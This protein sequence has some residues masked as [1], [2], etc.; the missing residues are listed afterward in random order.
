MSDADNLR[1]IYEE[2][3]KTNQV[4][5]EI[6]K[7]LSNDRNMMWKILGGTI[8]GAFMLIGIKMVI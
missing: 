6:K 5:D 3:V 1:G 7:T 8:A 2:L 4:L